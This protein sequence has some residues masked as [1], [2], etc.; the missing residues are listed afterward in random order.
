MASLQALSSSYFTTGSSKGLG[1]DDRLAAQIA[2]TFAVIDDD[3]RWPTDV[4][5]DLPIFLSDAI[6]AYGMTCDARIIPGLQ[7]FYNHCVLALSAEARM[8]VF[9]IVQQALMDG[10]TSTN[11]LFP[12]IF[13]ETSSG[14][15][16]SAALDYAVLEPTRQDD[17]LSGATIVARWVREGN[18]ANRA[19]VF[20]GLV[21]LGDRRLS[22]MLSN[23]R[24]RLSVEQVLEV[25]RTTTGYPT[26]GA[27]EFWL[28][29]A[30]DTLEMR[31][32]WTNLFGAVAA[33][34]INLVRAAQVPTFA[35]VERHFGYKP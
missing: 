27:L 14:I 1:M 24:G 22:A 31:M 3:A 29:W 16:C 30:H 8:E 32:G 9:R 23:L 33:G 10:C 26:V 12:I 2:E 17:P 11:A 5:R 7:R 15:V 25:A 34:L 19:A 35:E 28:Q 13:N 18:P 6:I 21:N 4:A 20:A